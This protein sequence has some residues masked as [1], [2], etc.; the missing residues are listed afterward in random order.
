MKLRVKY[1]ITIYG[2]EYYAGYEFA[3]TYKE[4]LRKYNSEVDLAKRLTAIPEDSEWYDDVPHQV[5]IRI[6]NLK[7]HKYVKSICVRKEG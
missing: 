2:N 6:K 7:T 5:Y 1:E 4:A 3:N